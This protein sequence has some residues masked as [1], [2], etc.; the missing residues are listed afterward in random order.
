MTEN[1]QKNFR[2]AIRWV[3]PLLA[4]AALLLILREFSS[5]LRQDWWSAFISSFQVGQR[6]PWLAAAM[7]LMPLNWLLESIKW[8][9]SV[10]HMEK[11][12]YLTALK[13]VLS[14]LSVSVFL[15]NRVGEYA[16]RVFVLRTADRIQAALSTMVAAF[17]QLIITLLLGTIAFTFYRPGFFGSFPVLSLS[18]L[19]ALTAL[20]L[21]FS[22]DA[23]VSRMPLRFIPK[24]L[25]HYRT[26]FSSLRPRVLALLLFQS[27]VRYLVF[28][29][30][31]FCL[32]RFFNI[33]IGPL[34]AFGCIAVTYL[35]MA[36]VPTIALTELGVRGAVAVMVFAPF[37][38]LSEEVVFASSLLWMVNLILPA[39][40]G[41]FFILKWKL[42]RSN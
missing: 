9:R 29:F 21:Y 18:W 10:L 13:G 6:L 17:S 3:K 11:V 42:V 16:G 41:C 22:V 38:E 28:C 5:A 15:P 1:T 7:L 8:R 34:I 33:A 24:R 12:S 30:Q 27:L 39:L 32:L 20:I 40:A 4:V 14:G 36:V 35:V 26:A 25:A 2:S 31:F 37:T 23:I 19:L